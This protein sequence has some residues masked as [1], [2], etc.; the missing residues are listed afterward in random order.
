MVK[1]MTSFF[2]FLLYMK[3]D[4]KKRIHRVE[5][6]AYIR[7]NDKFLL[8]EKLDQHFANT[9]VIYGLLAT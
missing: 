5:F 3:L 7:I 9:Y 8:K 6:Y 2:E 4:D 1:H